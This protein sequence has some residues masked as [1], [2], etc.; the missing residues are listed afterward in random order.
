MQSFRYGM[1]ETSVAHCVQE[2][3]HQELR[4]GAIRLPEILPNSFRPMPFP[5]LTFFRSDNSAWNSRQIC[6]TADRSSCRARSCEPEDAF[7]CTSPYQ[8]LPHA[9]VCVALHTVIH[10]RIT[11]FVQEEAWE[12]INVGTPLSRLALE[13]PVRK[14]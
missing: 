6:R 13:T 2:R 8:A 14:I 5:L 12:H 3:F 11:A 7:H 10:V 4:F 1:N 9:T